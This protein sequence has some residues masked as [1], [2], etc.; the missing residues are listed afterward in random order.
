[1]E[2]VEKGAQEQVPGE[3]RMGLFYLSFQ[4]GPPVA[5]APND[6]ISVAPT[7]VND[8]R[9]EIYQS[10]VE[11]GR[12]YI[13]LAWLKRH[14]E[15]WLVICNAGKVS[16]EGPLSAYKPC[17]VKVPDTSLLR[18]CD[19]IRLALWATTEATRESEQRKK[20]KVEPDDVLRWIFD[21]AVSFSY[22]ESPINFVPVLSA[23]IKVGLKN[24]YSNSSE[25]SSGMSRLFR[26][27][28]GKES[29]V[30]EI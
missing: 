21:V 28:G 2:R 29:A 12:V 3:K 19:T 24:T 11:Y 9:D 20:R 25:K 17:Q 23:P 27:G 1:V 4:R 26:I 7:I 14:Q 16:W 10:E 18:D 30:I 8:L 22:G 15:K 13:H 5:V 6:L